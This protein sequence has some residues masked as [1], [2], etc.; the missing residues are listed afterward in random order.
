MA[1]IERPLKTKATRDY[2]TEYAA[3]QPFALAQEV[4]ADFNTIYDGHNA[5]DAAVA[6]LAQQVPPAPAAND[7]GNV[8]TV[9]A[10]P[11]L[12]WA[13]PGG[14]PSGIPDAPLDGTTYGRSNAAWLRVL[15]LAGGALTG[16]LTLVADPVNA[17]DAATKRYVDALAGGAVPDAPNDGTIYGRGSAS[18]IHVLPLTGG[19]LSGPLML[20]ADPVQP[21]DAATK[22]YVDAAGGGGGG[23]PL[24][25]TGPGNSI[26]PITP[27][28]PL[29]QLGTVATDVLNLSRD[30][31]STAQITAYSGSPMEF[32]DAG[33]GYSW[34]SNFSG[35]DITL[36]RA[37]G[38]PDWGEPLTVNGALTLGPTRATTPAAGT[39]QWDGTHFAGY[40]ATAWV[41]LDEAGGGGGVPEA[42]TDGA[43]YGRGGTTP[44]WVGVL[45]L[46]G[47]TLTGP[48]LLAADPVAALGAATKAYVDAQVSG[49]GAP[50]GPAGGD[51]SGT[52]P[53]PALGIIQSAKVRL[54]GRGSF[55]SGPGGASVAVNDSA[56][57]ATFVATLPSWSLDFANDLGLDAAQIR[58][59]AANAGGSAYTA[60]LTVNPSGTIRVTVDPV[61]ALDLATRQFVLAQVGGGAPPSGP[62]GGSLAGTYPNPTLAASGVTPG[63][64]GGSTTIPVITVAADGRITTAVGGSLSAAAITSGTLLPDRTAQPQTVWTAA[65]T[66][67]ATQYDHVLN[68]ATANVDLTLPA[69]SAATLGVPY[70]FTRVDSS[71]LQASIAGASTDTV[72]GNSFITIAPGESVTIIAVNNIQNKKWVTVA[73]QNWRTIQAGNIITPVDPNKVLVSQAAGNAL[74]WGARTVKGRLGAGLVADA[75]SSLALSLNFGYPFNAGSSDNTG[76]PSWMLRLQ[77]TGDRF[78]VMRAPATSGVPVFA[79]LLTVD[80][81]GQLTLSGASA[82]FI[83]QTVT[84]ATIQAY[85]FPTFGGSYNCNQARGSYA[86]PTATQQNDIIGQYAGAGYS[87]AYNQQGLLRWVAAENWTA[88]A[89]GCNFQVYATATGTTGLTMVQMS[90]GV[91]NLTIAGAAAV[92]ASGTTWANP[93]DP[94]LKRDVAP[95]VTGLDAI[96]ALEP[97]SFF[98]N[99]K[100]G[101]RDDGMQ[102][103]G[104]DASAVQGVLPE[105][106]GMRRGKLDEADA[107]DTDIMTLDTSNFTL[108]LINAVKELAARVTALEPGNR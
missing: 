105:C 85:G 33:G 51:L 71:A 55:F 31:S 29:G 90:D 57:D 23:D 87:T 12:T 54:V 2:S 8:L 32:H 70:R 72:D 48:L 13:A 56:H 69:W 52:Y 47:G 18:W 107:E 86:A 24:W 108:A 19:T 35:S 25:E 49:G 76:E 97:I 75:S 89:R 95:Y 36:C 44:A 73:R 94:R 79:P 45:P 102:C 60:L 84:S 20:A 17:L 42:P 100:G 98:Y 6:V 16:V 96:L 62:A 5:L 106:V 37:Y 64:W 101:T 83:P 53:N 26:Q 3:G 28:A 81:T 93:S 21:L 63:I 41:N 50:S 43:I 9:A 65:G 30:F 103:Y 91:G 104:Y 61:N 78:D 77:G 88:S 46:A 4:D 38:N 99:G 58:R 59:R 27:G 34:S 67:T 1:S 82:L 11:T 39:I 66:V 15:P 14:G 40:N 68:A 22:Q 74:T 80:A 92:K 10:G 7:V